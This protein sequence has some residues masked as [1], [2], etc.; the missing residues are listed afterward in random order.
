VVSAKSAMKLK[1]QHL[2]LVG[3]LLFFAGVQFRMVQ[4]FTLNER[5]THFVAARMGAGPAP[6]PQSA[7]QTAPERR[8]VQPPRWLGLALMSIGSVLTLKSLSMKGIA[9][10]P[11]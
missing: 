10:P 11:V 4:S 5:S 1:R 3:L 6:Q 2:L 8:V 7:W 9:K